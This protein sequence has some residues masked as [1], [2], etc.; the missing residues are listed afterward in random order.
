[1]KYN[2]TQLISQKVN[3]VKVD[4]ILTFNQDDDLSTNDTFCSAPVMVTGA[5]KR[6]GKNFSLELHYES[7][8][9]FLCGRCLGETEY[10]VEGEI[11]RSIVKERNDAEDD[12]VYVES[13]VID[14]YDV[15]YNDIVL[16]LPTQVICDDDCKGLCPDCGINL[17]T[18]SCNCDDENIDPRLAKLKNLFTHTEEV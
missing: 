7:K 12:N 3:E 1:M 6:N 9:T 5:I 14:L 8:W 16:N 13:A 10:V 17:N 18:D 15:I 4:S 2:L 11:M